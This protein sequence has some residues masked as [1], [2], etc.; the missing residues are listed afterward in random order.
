VLAVD[1]SSSG[2]HRLA[3]LKAVAD[4]NISV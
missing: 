4:S 2:E 1:V 3:G